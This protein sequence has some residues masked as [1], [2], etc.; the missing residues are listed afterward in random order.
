MEKL[1]LGERP[2]PRVVGRGSP[3]AKETARREIIERF[4]DQFI[5]LD[6]EEVAELTAEEREKTDEQ[7]EYIKVANEI[8]NEILR[9]FGLT[10][11]DVPE[12][13][14]HIISAKLWGEKPSVRTATMITVPQR[15]GILVKGDYPPQARVQKAL[16]LFHE[17]VH[18]KAHLSLEAE[19]NAD[20]HLYRS[21][22]VT[23]ATYAKTNRSGNAKWF[24]GLNEAV[25]TQME[26][27]YAERV[28]DS[29]PYL[30]DQVEYLNSEEVQKLKSEHANYRHIDPGE[31]EW[32]GKDGDEIEVFYNGYRKQ[33]WVLNYVVDQIYADGG[34]ASRDEVMNLFFA[35]HFKDSLLPLGRA[36]EKSFGKGSFEFLGTME[37][38]GDSASCGRVLDFLMKRRKELQNER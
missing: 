3:E 10:E 18:A 16:S 13:N 17:M 23:Y 19:S 32:I 8:T 21:G 35:A 12:E 5:D 14:V 29:N 20:N 6:E 30:R 11:F 1:P 4:Q 33:R 31:I 7:K 37:E 15:Q 24:E 26:M 9:E 28:L 25:V 38:D 36:V 2:E 34:F 27:K 22:L